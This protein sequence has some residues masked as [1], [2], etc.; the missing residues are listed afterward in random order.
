M[1]RLALC[2]LTMALATAALACVEC[3]PDVQ[4]GIFD[5]SFGRNLAAM[6]SPLLVLVGIGLLS[7]YLEKEE[8]A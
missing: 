7:G 4:A 3:R 6:L 8:R 1:V 2:V 5:G